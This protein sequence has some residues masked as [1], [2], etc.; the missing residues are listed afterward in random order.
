VLPSADEPWGLAI[1]EAMCAGIPIIA[2]SEIG[3]VPDLVR[4]GDNG[5]IF[6]AGNVVA[7]TEAL[8]PLLADAELRE[9]MGQASR[10]IIARWNYEECEAGLAAALAA[11][12]VAVPRS[13]KTSGVAAQ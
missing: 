4:E 10:D 1:N 2:S 12:G 13:G 9:R 6:P 11:V 3:C 8:L 7:L 5:R